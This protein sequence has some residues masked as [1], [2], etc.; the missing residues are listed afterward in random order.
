MVNKKLFVATFIGLVILSIIGSTGA[1]AQTQMATT[2]ANATA[3][4]ATASATT[5]GGFLGLPGFEAVYAVAG[6]LIVAYLVM[7]RRR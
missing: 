5:S 3:A 1:F 4:A 7:Q 2:T 6:L